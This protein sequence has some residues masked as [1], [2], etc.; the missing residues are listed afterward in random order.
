MTSNK[1]IKKAGILIAAMLKIAILMYDRRV[2]NTVVEQISNITE[3]QQCIWGKWRIT[4]QWYGGSGWQECSDDRKEADIQFFPESLSFEG[5]TIQV[6]SY[7]NEFLAIENENLLFHGES[8]GN[9]GFS[10]GYF[11]KFYT[12]YVDENQDICPFSQFVL[13][14]DTGMIIPSGRALYKAEKLG[15]NTEVKEDKSLE[16]SSLNSMC[17]GVWEITERVNE[18]KGVEKDN[19]IG[20][21][22][23][24]S[25]EL[26]SF[27]SCKVFSVTDGKINGLV[28]VMGL[29][30]NTYIVCYEF[31]D[32]FYWD[33]MI[34]KDAMTAIVVK[35]DE[36]YWIER[37][38]NPVKDGI[39]NEVG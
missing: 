33:K 8:F 17:Y 34:I 30:K 2:D 29:E 39:Y 24:T 7:P 37:K 10:E 32:G 3:T 13:M 28:E 4:E 23:I 25:E 18:N 38:S 22:L 35:E 14:S 6:S 1:I 26:N 5:V 21:I 12:D 20:E 19:Y 15:E 11:L 27:V 9:L 31:S 36:L 16:V